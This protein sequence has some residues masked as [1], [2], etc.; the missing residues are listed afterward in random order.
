MRNY[1]SPIIAEKK[2]EFLKSDF[3]KLSKFID[4]FYEF[5]ES[6][7]NPLEVLETFYER[8]E[9]NNQTPIFIDKILFDCGF[10]IQKPL[11]ISK[12]ELLLHLRDFYLSRGSEESFKF[13]YKVLYNSDVMID[14]PR[15][16][17][18]IPSQATYSGRYFVFTSTNTLGTPKFESILALSDNFELFLRGVSS[19]VQC[20]VEGISLVRS[21]LN[22]YLKIQ[23]D[24]PYRQFQKGEGIEIIAQSTG[25]K[26]VENF[27]D[28]LNVEIVNPGKGYAIGDKVSI[29]NTAIMGNARVRTLKEGSISDVEITAGGSGYA[30]GDQIRTSTRAK[31]HSFSAVV[32]KIDDSYNYLSVPSHS[33][34]EL[35]SGDF[36][37]ECWVYMPYSITDSVIC[38]N[39]HPAQNNGWVFKMSG[40][41]RLVFQMF[42]AT[43]STFTSTRPVSINKWVHIAATRQNNT[44]RLFIDGSMVSQDT[45]SSGSAS[46]TNLRIGLGTDSKNAFV[47]YMSELRITRSVARYTSSFALP[48]AAFDSDDPEFSSVT[49]LMH[50][51]GL[52]NSRTFVDS[53]QNAHSVTT[54]TQGA[55]YVTTDVFKF[56]TTSC[57][58]SGLG[59]ITKIDIY[60]HGYNY[61]S[62]PEYVIQSKRG[63]GAVLNLLSE[64]I[65]QIESIEILDPYVDSTGSPEATMIS[66][67]GTGAV[68]NAVSQSVFTEPFSWKSFEGVL[69]VNCTLLDSYYY[70][71]FSYYTYSSI[72]RKESDAIVDEW[73]HP[74]GFVRF[75]ILDISYTGFIWSAAHGLEHQFYLTIIKLIRGPDPVFMVNPIYYL[76]WFKELSPKN[77]MNWVSGFDWQKEEWTDDPYYYISQALD[78][79][80][81]TKYYTI[82]DPRILINPQSRLDWFK[83]STDN[84]SYTIE[85]WDTMTSGDPPLG[86]SNPSLLARKRVN[87][88]TLMMNKALD[89]EIDITN[90]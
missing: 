41:R 24:A 86:T 80:P 73:C 68:L 26:I 88:D 63:T 62:I 82:R 89:A 16:K 48:V 44:L 10:D 25:D 59:S 42:G 56:N 66:K 20:A 46:T 47:G 6:Q 9:A 87:D 22:T 3:K 11:V 53:S 5:L 75:A 17:M 1:I 43:N 76:H 15:K 65:G 36:T 39:K 54:P 18:L 64:G 37:I 71:Q 40:S 52:N 4:H 34:F 23:I 14:Y 55:V 28:V 60:N 90:L 61:D 69:G 31:G 27:V 67:N 21:T 58:F 79:Y 32:S 84:Y 85:N 38:S 19:K 81:V 51:I 45:V 78:I 29:S 12:K 33:G 13:L 72:P 7:G 83:E 30:I 74:S 8:C 2:P 35:T 57:F 50:F 49:L 70:Q 77:Y